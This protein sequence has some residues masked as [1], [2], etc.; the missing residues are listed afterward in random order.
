MT[1]EELHR[2]RVQSGLFGSTL[3]PMGQDPAPYAQRQQEAQD[4]LVN[5]MPS[6]ET[7]QIMNATQP[8][9]DKKSWFSDL[10]IKD[11]AALASAAGI[12]GAMFMPGPPKPRRV[13]GAVGGPGGNPF[14]R[15]SV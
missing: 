11:Y 9:A 8:A 6:Q 14:L 15:R 1:P 13:G 2:L 4:A 7:Q 3:V 12:L 10:D 5:G